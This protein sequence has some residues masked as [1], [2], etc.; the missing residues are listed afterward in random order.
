MSQNMTFEEMKREIE[1]IISKE[2]PGPTVV[3]LGAVLDYRPVNLVKAAAMQGLEAESVPTLFE[4]VLSHFIERAGTD[5]GILLAE[6]YL[7]DFREEA[8]RRLQLSHNV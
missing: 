1:N 2:P 8:A 3:N 4:I 7:M 6:I 5:A